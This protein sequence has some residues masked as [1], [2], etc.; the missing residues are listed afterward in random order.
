MKHGRNAISIWQSL[1]FLIWMGF[2][3]VITFSPW[4]LAIVHKVTK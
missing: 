2:G 4:V 3:F 1:T